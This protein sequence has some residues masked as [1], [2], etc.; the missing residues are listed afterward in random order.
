ETRESAC[1]RLLGKV[2]RQQT[3]LR[4]LVNLER[5]TVFRRFLKHFH[6]L[7]YENFYSSPSFLSAHFLQR[8]HH[9][10]RPQKPKESLRT[11]HRDDGRRRII[12]R[13]KRCCWLHPSECAEIE[14]ARDA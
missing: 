11:R 5:E 10:R 14:I 13:S 1:G 9:R 8:Q 2:H 3:H 4:A 12:V 7:M 6:L